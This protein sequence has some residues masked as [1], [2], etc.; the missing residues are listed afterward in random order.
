MGIVLLAILTNKVDES[1]LEVV[2]KKLGYNIVD[3]CSGE[4]APCKNVEN[5]KNTAVI[6]S[7]ACLQQ[8]LP[9]LDMLD[10]NGEKYAL[11]AITLKTRSTGSRR[12]IVSRANYTVPPNKNLISELLYVADRHL[13]RTKPRVVVHAFSY[14]KGVPQHLDFMFDCRFINNPFRVAEL[15]HKSGLNEEV[16]NFCFSQDDSIEIYT[17]FRNAVLATLPHFME[18]GITCINVGFGCTGG[19]HRSVSFAYTFAS[20]LQRQGIEVQL[21]APYAI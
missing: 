5:C 13:Y 17:D 1:Q 16:R 8:L 21:S 20:D 9:H 18:Q 15:R 2:F 4:P 12:A 3:I 10:N 11:A 7:G 6:Y 14:K 19:R